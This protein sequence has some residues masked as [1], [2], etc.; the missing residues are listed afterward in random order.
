MGM[1]KYGTY[2]IIQTFFKVIESLKLGSPE[3]KKEASFIEK[4]YEI[5]IAKI[6]SDPQLYN[7]RQ[8]NFQMQ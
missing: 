5:L 8:I 1:P 4:S 6:S 3:V 7:R 2:S